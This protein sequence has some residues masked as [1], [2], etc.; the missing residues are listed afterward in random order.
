MAYAR[1]NGESD[2]YF[3]AHVNGGWQCV[4]CEH[5]NDLIPTRQAAIAHLKSHLARG[6]RV[7]ESALERLTEEYRE[8]FPTTW[9]YY[10]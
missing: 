1:L 3:I 4:G 7:P 2:V 8:E 9:R 5:D 6:D 10:D